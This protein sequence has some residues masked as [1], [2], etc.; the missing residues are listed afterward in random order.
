MDI[1]NLIRDFFGDGLVLCCRAMTYR[2]GSKIVKNEINL[3]KSYNSLK[4][5]LKK[6]HQDLFKI[7]NVVNKMSEHLQTESVVLKQKFQQLQ[8]EISSTVQRDDFQK[9]KVDLFQKETIFNAVQ[10]L[11]LDLFNL[12]HLFTMQNA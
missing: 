8:W 4:E 5:A 9:L 10:T 2:Q 12:G 3:G 11:Q 7:N 1:F 6:E